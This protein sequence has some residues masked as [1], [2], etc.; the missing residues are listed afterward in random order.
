MISPEKMIN[1]AKMMLGAPIVSIELSDEQMYSLI[2]DAQDSL[3]LYSEIAKLEEKDY[4]R[5]ESLWIKK[6]F[7]ALC[8]EALGRIRGKYDSN[9]PT[10]GGD[11]KLNYKELLTESY[12]EKKFLKYLILKDNNVLNSNDDII[13]V[14]YV[15]IVGVDSYEVREYINK[16]K[17]NLDKHDSVTKYFIPCNGETRIECIYPVGIDITQTEEG[18]KLIEKMND[19]FFE[20]KEDDN[21]IG[22][23][24]SIDLNY[25]MVGVEVTEV[26]DEVVK[27]KYHN[28]TPDR[29]EEFSIE[30]FEK[31]TRIK[32]RKNEQ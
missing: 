14:F 32:I 25:T 27:V 29:T 2:N 23:T 30:D 24:F 12:R 15:N 10:T 16:V 28:S 7:Y 1:G 17:K 5:I 31:L 11:L 22:K 21:I 26:T 6:Y 20:D 9:L 4:M 13:L 19:H 3:V 8:K 18:K